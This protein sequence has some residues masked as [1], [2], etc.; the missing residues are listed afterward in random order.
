MEEKKVL[1]GAKQENFFFHFNFPKSR[2]EKMATSVYPTCILSLCSF[3]SI[4]CTEWL[5]SRIQD[6]ITH[7]V[8]IELTNS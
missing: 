8:V 5:A 2:K 6:L 3:A 7:H 4:N 1:I